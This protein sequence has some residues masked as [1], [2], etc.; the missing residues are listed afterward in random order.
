MTSMDVKETN[1]LNI[2]VIQAHALTNTQAHTNEAT[3]RQTYKQFNLT[4]ESQLHSYFQ[5]NPIS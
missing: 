4:V 1:S 2:M 5:L 3:V